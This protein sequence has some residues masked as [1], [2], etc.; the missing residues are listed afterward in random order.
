MTLKL[1]ETLGSSTMVTRR[2]TREEI[3]RIA[4]GSSTM[5]ATFVF[6]GDYNRSKDGSTKPEAYVKNISSTP[7]GAIRAHQETKEQLR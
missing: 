3:K 2:L 7:K 1:E 4:P 5:Y 6:P